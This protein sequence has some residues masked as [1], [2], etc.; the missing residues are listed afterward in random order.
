M[1]WGDCIIEEKGEK[2]MIGRLHLG[3]DLKKTKW[4]WTW[5]PA[6]DGHTTPDDDGSTYRRHHTW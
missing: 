6:A 3:G 4:K 5:L 1:D 2:T